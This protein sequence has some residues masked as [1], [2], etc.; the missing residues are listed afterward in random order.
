MPSPVLSAVLLLNHIQSHG[1]RE[2]FLLLYIDEDEQ[3]SLS[4]KDRI[5]ENNVS[6]VF[7]VYQ[8]LF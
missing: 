8:L 4:A 6:E 5:N 1:Y 3:L 7:A 2:T